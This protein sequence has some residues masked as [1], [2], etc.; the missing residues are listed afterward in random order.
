MVVRISKGRFD[1][2]RAAEVRAG[3]DESRRSLEPAIRR[4]RGLVA[5]HVGIDV[6]T[7]TMTNTS[8]WR[9]REDAMQMRGLPEMLALRGTF[10]T[11]GVE[12]DPITNHEV[13]WSLSGLP[14]ITSEPA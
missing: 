9:T 13:L 1:P 4:L 7:S 3:L 14:T 8:V 6:E 2:A 10:E 11:L 12:F 5:Y